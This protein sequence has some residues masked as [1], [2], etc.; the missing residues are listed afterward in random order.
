V[1]IDDSGAYSVPSDQDAELERLAALVDAPDYSDNPGKAPYFQN[2]G[3]WK[4]DIA[5]YGSPPQ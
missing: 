3:I 2:V 4:N 5:N 1:F